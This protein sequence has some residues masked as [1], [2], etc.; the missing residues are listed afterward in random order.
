MSANAWKG[1][2]HNCQY[3]RQVFLPSEVFEWEAK[4]SHRLDYVCQTPDLSLRQWDTVFL[5]FELTTLRTHGEPSFHMIG[6]LLK[7]AKA[8]TACFRPCDI[9]KKNSVRCLKSQYSAHISSP[10]NV[11]AI[12]ATLSRMSVSELGKFSKLL[13]TL[14]LPEAEGQPF[15]KTVKLL[16]PR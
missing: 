16:Y 8:L 13:Q 15:E 4:S 5:V 12:W 7:I 6:D 11:W 2:N 3:S 9:L 10:L 14:K 1:L